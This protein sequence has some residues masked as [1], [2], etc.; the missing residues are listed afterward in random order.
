MLLRYSGVVAAVP[1]TDERIS[2]LRA[3]YDRCYGCGSQNPIGLHLDDFAET[4]T[5]VSA[6]FSPD[7]DFNGF[8]DIVHGGIIATGLDEISAWAAIVAEGVFVF[9]AKLE[10]KYRAEAHTSDHFTLEGTVEERRGKRLMIHAALMSDDVVVAESSGLFIVA[11]TIEELIANR[12]DV[13][14]K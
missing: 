14:T 10:I 7:R 8:H 12:R 9:T 13:T 6:P 3:V 5:G 2:V 11:G 1:L 4:P